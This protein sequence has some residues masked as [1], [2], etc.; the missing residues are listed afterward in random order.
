MTTESTSPWKICYFHHPFYTHARFHG[1]DIDLRAKIEPLFIKAGVNLVLT[2]HQH[3]YE[4]IKPQK[5]IYYFV[6]GNAGEL[7]YHDL[8]PSPDTVKGFDTDRD[9]MLMEIAGD[10]LYFQT[11]SRTGETIDSGVLPRQS[12]PANTSNNQSLEVLAYAAR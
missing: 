1:A 4:R 10:D 3:V 12:A 9:F 2:G 5:G 6:L 8:Q 7:R 11:I